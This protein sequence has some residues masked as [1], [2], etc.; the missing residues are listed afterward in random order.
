MHEAEAEIKR[1][2]LSDLI[3]IKNALTKEQ[4]D[5]LTELRSPRVR[6]FRGLGGAFSRDTT[7]AGLLLPR[8][9]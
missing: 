9:R 5:Q 3:R 1:A 4:R 7:A 2:N 6:V 8:P